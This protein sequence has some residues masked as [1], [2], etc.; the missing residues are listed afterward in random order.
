MS[1]RV[2]LAK[3]GNQVVRKKKRHALAGDVAHA[4]TQKVKVSN[5]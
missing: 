1:S 4:S 3:A 5:G 2:H